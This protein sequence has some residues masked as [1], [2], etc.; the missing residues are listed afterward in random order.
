MSRDGFD[1]LIIGAGPAGLSAAVLADELGLSVLLLDEQG[2]PGGQ[3]YQ[4][5]ESVDPKIAAL[6]GA[7][8]RRGAALAEAFRRSGAQYR[9]GAT[10]WRVD[11]DGT[12]AYSRDGAARIVSARRVLLAT[13]AQERPTPIPGWTLP[14]VMSAGGAQVLL[15]SAGIIP[16][17]PVVVAGNGPLA[18]LITSQLIAAGANIAALLETTETND[19]IAALPH[20]PRAMQAARL[21]TPE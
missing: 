3:I 16:T 14:G 1:L 5:I 8:Y 19:Y 15:K 9:S 12:V 10:V 20:L 7:D 21:A 2:E 13:G 4:A 6:L 18:L 17:G 11:A